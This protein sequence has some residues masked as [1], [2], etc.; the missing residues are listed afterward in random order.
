MIGD[1]ILHYKILEKL[2]EGGM[3]VVYKAEDIKLKR[4]VAI[5]FLPRFI[6]SNKEE[7][8]RFEIEAQAAAALN[9][10]NISTIHAIENA[11]DQIFIVME[12][13]DGIEL[14]ERL[15]AGPIPIKETLNVSRQIAE[16]LEA[17]HSKGIIHRDIKS[18]NIMITKDGNAKIMDFGLAKIGHGSEITK[19]GTTIG[20]TGY[21]SPEQTRGEN[22]DQQTDIW[23]FGIVLYEMLTGELPFKGEYDQA[24]IYS[25][26][27]ID[28]QPVTKYSGNDA[29]I[30][31]RILKKCLEKNQTDRYKTVSDIIK[32][33]EYSGKENQLY[34]KK[35]TSRILTKR[36]TT[37]KI[38]TL[39]GFIVGIIIL[40]VLLSPQW[41]KIKE[42]VGLETSPQ[43][44]HLLILPF[45][46]IGGGEDK[47][48]FCDGLME[49]LASKLTQLEQYEGSLW[50]VPASEVIRNK[51]KSPNE[52]HKMYGVNLT[53]TGS[54]QFMNKIFRLTL[55]LV[56]AKNLRQ[57]NSSVID[58][59]E[60]DL[61]SLQ[62]NSIIK[63]L[64]MLNIQLKPELKDVLKS[65][66][67]KVPEAYAYYV[68][69]RGQLLRYE[70]IEN[71]DE[72]VNS[73]KLSTESDNRY[74]LAYAGLGE[75]YWRKYEFTKNTDLVRK[76]IEECEYA[77]RLDSLLAPVNI[78]LGIIY[79]GTGRY[80]DAIRQ[81]NKALLNDQ[82]NAAIYR[83]LAKVYESQGKNDEAEK[84]YQKAIKLKPGYWA[85]Y[86]DLGVFYYKNSKYENAIKQFKKLI[87]LTPDN[88]RGYNNLGGIYYVLKR[89]GEAREMF[90]RSLSIRKSYNIYTNLGTL[91]YIEGK[92]EDAARTYLLALELNDKDY[93]TW[94][95]LA[96]AYYGI[97]GKK[98]KAIETYKRT[99]EIAERQL[100]INPNDP[101]VISNLASY[102]SDIGNKKKSLSLLEK[103]L[104]LAP[105]NV[106]VVYRAATTYE[107]LGNRDK[108]LHW[109][110]IAVNSGF[111]SSEIEHQ[112]E[113]KE[114]VADERFKKLL[115]KYNNSNK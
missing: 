32:D 115:E 60:K 54:L 58:I 106:Q 85:G 56:D 70:N 95:N 91:Y 80:A 14:K 62:D 34:S 92:F 43:V 8:Q 107:R 22:V 3:G 31:E 81:F 19:I 7:Q 64:E 12:F 17:A 33:F 6:S 11:A 4:D 1:T 87:E 69:G 13:I 50:V 28:Y 89:W 108:A 73:F 98:E 55:N 99:I 10:P 29:I 18:S 59:K 57:L 26:N 41:K 66:G 68:Q 82:S 96:A 5:K 111:S 84:T 78:T 47:Q 74:S 20:T 46:N 67:T 16:A 21:M 2:G 86:N 110:G 94:G 40:S 105:E 114:L 30:I 109:I 97:P 100:K 37:K 88:Y 102:Y 48:A 71:I 61:F 63:L 113:L 51:I 93:L 35:E 39:T 79:T 90:E 77:F 45:T 53:V 75:S 44:Q 65:G 36:L 9:H 27:S 101:N 76:A 24:I 52:A 104:K 25:I 42:L 83:G 72:A 38:V 15:K 103:S 112:P 23:S 49:T